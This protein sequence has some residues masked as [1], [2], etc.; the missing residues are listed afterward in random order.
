MVEVSRRANFKRYLAAAGSILDCMGPRTPLRSGPSVRMYGRR[1]ERDLLAGYAAQLGPGC[2]SMLLLGEAGMGKTTLW[3]HG[4]ALCRAAGAT[5]LVTRPDE[6]DRLRPGQGLLDILGSTGDDLAS[7]SALLGSTISPLERVRGVQGYLCELADDKPVVL[8]IDDLPWLDDLT[9]QALRF[10]LRRLG[11]S[12]LSVLATART[13]SPVLPGTVAPPPALGHELDEVPVP[14]MPASDVSRLIRGSF[15]GA[16]WGL[17]RKI[18]DLSHGNPLL[19]LE[20]ARSSGDPDSHALGT[21]AL[22]DVLERRMRQL[23]PATVHLARLLAVAGPTPLPVLLPLLDGTG[24][25]VGPVLQPG[26]DSDLLWLEDDFLLRLEHPMV[27]V[28]ALQGVN[29]LD[30]CELHRQLATVVPDPDDRASHLAL[31][32]MV[33][34]DVVADQVEQA[35]ARLAGRGAQQASAELYRHS[36][37]L[38]TDPVGPAGVRRR[39][40]ELRHTA[41]AGDAVRAGELA[42]ALLSDLPPGP[43]RAQVVTRRVEL[44]LLDAEPFL[45]QGL[46][47]LSGTAGIEVELLRGRLLGLLG[48]LLALHLG[49][50][51]EGLEHARAGLELGRAH[52]DTTLIAQ[53]AATVDTAL[54]LLGRPQEGLIEEA[55]GLDAPVEREHLIMWPRVLHGRQQLWQGHLAAARMAHEVTYEQSLRLGVDVQLSYRWHDLATVALAEGDL[56]RAAQEAEAGADV[57]ISAGDAEAEVWLAYPAGMV[58]ALRGDEGRALTEAGHLDRR[59]ARAGQRP[60]SAMAAHVRGTLAASSGD[61]PVALEHY[62]SALSVL[63]HAGIEHPGVVPVL[64]SALLVAVFADRTDLL[65]ELAGRLPV[66]D[67]AAPWVAAQVSVAQAL[68]RLVDRDAEALAPLVDAHTR[69]LE[70]GYQLDA[71][72]LACVLGWAGARSGRTVQVRPALEHARTFLSAR[73]VSGWAELAVN[74]HG[75][76]CGEPGLTSLTST[77]A[78]VAGLVAKG[79]RNKEIAQRLY[80]SESTVEAHL[81]RIYRK[82]GLPNRAALTNRVLSGETSQG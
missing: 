44:D 32:T 20:L 1:G 62:L 69:L 51:E 54:L 15:P 52:G 33:Q 53:T 50:P 46:L 79:C 8:A 66:A 74:L 18:A 9:A 4:V 45:L 56:D 38:T 35:A 65:P 80:V 71:A 29:A 27:G 63:A 78:Q 39:L 72:R 61:W 70:L 10:S 47:D 21:S 12:A 48:W 2:R 6:E 13:P 16:T 60:R 58:A 26:L 59:A 17:A 67:P 23:P 24:S 3:Q 40:A 14:P 76:V 55:V 34:D 73:T 36:A 37:R 22:L 28:A 31:A 30:R 57:A 19:A 5:V 41:A 49:R 77:E 11:G 68:M 75:R 43:L 81:T 64:P 42:T 82:L 7:P 25:D